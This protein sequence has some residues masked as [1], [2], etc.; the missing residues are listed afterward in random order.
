MRTN[1][2]AVSPPV[3]TEEG[4]KGARIS[5]ELTLRRLCMTALLFEKQFYQSGDNHVKQ[6]EEVVK[7]LVLQGKGEAVMRTAIECRTMMYLRHMPLFMLALLT[8]YPGNGHWVAKGLTVC[9]QRADEL[10]E[11]VAIYM[12]LFPDAIRSTID[13]KTD[14]PTGGK[15]GVKLSA[16]AKRGL[17]IAF[18]KF[19]AYDLAKYNRDAAVKLVDVLRLVRPKPVNAEQSAVWE[20]L[21]AGTLASPDTWEVALSAGAD[22]KATWERLLTEEKLGGLAFL[23][24]LRNM[25]Q[26]GVDMA[27]IRARFSGDFK[28][29][30]PF[31]FI[32]ALNHA[33]T[34]AAELDAA[35]LRATIGLPKLTGRTAILVD[36]SGSMKDA[37]SSKSD[38]NRM[39][40]ASALAVLA[41][42][43]CDDCQLFTFSDNVAVVPSFRGLALIDSIIKSQPH[44]GTYLT[45][46]MG[47]IDKEV[48]AGRVQPFN[49]VIIITDEQTHDGIQAAGGLGYVINVGANKVG[50]GY[51]DKGWTHI[52]G[53]SERILDFIYRSEQVDAGAVAGEG[54]DGE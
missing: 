36:V 47:A 51:G 31:R 27:L 3:F 9:V 6:V 2:R 10:G 13:Y 32:A 43:V 19:S 46:A 52:D 28:R 4:G 49:R 11:F 21:I 22:K 35:M 48:A 1:T 7:E 24:N 34:L 38:M 29:V 15:L 25:Q 54:T 37:M 18:R 14:K 12:Q 40:A 8:K 26:A 42:E 20:Q 53:F 30:L 33:P 5:A 41:R 23:R 45:G 44:H 50:V 39:Q 17:A 16:G